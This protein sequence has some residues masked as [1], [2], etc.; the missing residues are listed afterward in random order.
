MDN[1]I[2]ETI[3]LKKYIW[4]DKQFCIHLRQ[5]VVTRLLQDFQNMGRRLIYMLKYINIH[6]LSDIKKTAKEKQR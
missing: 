1:V 4:I 5:W 6:R 2:T 3:K